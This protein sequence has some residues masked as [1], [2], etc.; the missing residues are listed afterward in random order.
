MYIA[1]CDNNRIQLWAPGASSGTTIV[2]SGSDVGQVS[3]PASVYLDGDGRVYISDAGND[4]IQQYGFVISRSDTPI[5]PGI[6]TAVVNTGCGIIASNSI[7]IYGSAPPS[8]P[9]DTLLCPQSEVQ[10]NTHSAY[11]SY[12]WQDGSTDSV[13][14]VTAPGT[15]SVKVTSMCGGPFSAQT[16]VSLDQ[17][18]A[19]FLPVDTEVCSYGGLLLKP[20]TD[21]TTY[22]WSDGSTGPTI[23]INQPGLYWLEGTDKGGCS[24]TDSVSVSSKACPPVGVY[25]PSAFTPNGDGRNDVFRPE[26]FGVVSSYSFS[27][28]DRYGQLVFSSKEPGVGWD[29]KVGGAQPNSNVFV[30]YCMFQL[31]GQQ[32]KMEKG[33]VVLVR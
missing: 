26:I 17:T 12:L 5:T 33:T 1:D 25:V 7:T 9:A 11:T 14:T 28:Y 2:G 4:R 29:G 10:L 16:I 23:T 19:D 21:F 32:M 20:T 30:W 3:A 31:A 8:L 27:V 18:P 24:A 15:Y 13:F 22:L 6:Y